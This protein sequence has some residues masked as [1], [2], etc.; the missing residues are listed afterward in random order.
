MNETERKYNKGPGG[1]LGPASQAGRPAS[2]GTEK[3]QKPLNSLPFQAFGGQNGAGT[4]TTSEAALEA[5]PA[6]RAAWEHNFL[7]K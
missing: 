5:W 2:W 3:L 7:N 6:G 4:K 1:L